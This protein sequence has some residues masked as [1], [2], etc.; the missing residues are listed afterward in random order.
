[1]Q[2]RGVPA[3]SEFS[4]RARK[5]KMQRPLLRSPEAHHVPG[6]IH[7]R[8]AF[9]YMLAFSFPGIFKLYLSIER[10]FSIVYQSSDILFLMTA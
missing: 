4:L 3:A 6:A 1:M 10:F 7:I 5:T 8:C 9:L 2:A